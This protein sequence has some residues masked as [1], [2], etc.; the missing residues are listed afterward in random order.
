VRDFHAA[1][2]QLAPLGQGVNVVTNSN[3]NHAATIGQSPPQPQPKENEN[4]SFHI[5]K[6]A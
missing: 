3:M 5:C 6:T 2:D 4:R 1:K